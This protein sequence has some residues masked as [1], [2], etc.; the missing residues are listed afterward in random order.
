MPSRERNVFESGGWILKKVEDFSRLSDFDCGDADLN[1]FFRK[2]C[3]Q[4]KQELLNET[5]EIVEATVE[6]AFPVALISLCNDAVRKQK[7]LELLGFTDKK[8]IY[9]YY[10]AVKIARLGVS[11][12][13]QRKDI[14]THLV[15]MIKEMFLTDNRT[16]C[17]LLTVDSYNKPHVINFYEKRNGFQFFPGEERKKVTSEEDFKKKPRSL[18]MFYD[19]KR[20]RLS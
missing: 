7:V 17:R 12:E 9:P 2:D 6:D 8:K 3:F 5:Y 1:E 10:P 19:L 18:T 4:Q 11:K 20:L 13:L 15:N 16:G 14:G